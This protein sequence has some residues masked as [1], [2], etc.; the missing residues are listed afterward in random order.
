MTPAEAVA[1]L[2]AR[3][4]EN[5]AEIQRRIDVLG[6]RMTPDM[7]ELLYSRTDVPS[8]QALL[9]YLESDDRE[10]EVVVHQHV[11]YV[12][13]AESLTAARVQLEH[14]MW[15]DDNSE[16]ID[17]RRLIYTSAQVVLEDS[18]PISKLED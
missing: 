14:G 12:F 7:I 16:V 4:R 13:T 9:D 1:A 5:V 8:M 11:R 10:V 15:P 18:N 6:S 2:D 3:H 17:H